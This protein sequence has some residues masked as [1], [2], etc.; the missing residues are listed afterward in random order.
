MDFR[1]S[2]PP[3]SSARH[4]Y[5]HYSDSTTDEGPRHHRFFHENLHDR[6]VS[7]NPPPPYGRDRD[8]D[9]YEREP[10]RPAEKKQ[11]EKKETMS[12]WLQRQASSHSVQLAATAVLSGAVVAGA[13]FGVQNARRKIAVED[14]KASIPAADEEHEVHDVCVSPHWVYHVI[15]LGPEVI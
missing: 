15:G 10:S 13:I 3:V 9:I 2:R 7:S 5:R 8:R 14:L 1:Y 11:E 4:D 6:Y 12:S